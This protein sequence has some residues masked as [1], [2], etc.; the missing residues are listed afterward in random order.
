MNRYEFP[1]LDALRRNDAVTAWGMSAVAA[2]ALGL[3]TLLPNQTAKLATLS[4]ASGSALMSRRLHTSNEELDLQLGDDRYIARLSRQR[5]LLDVYGSPLSST[6]AIA[7]ATTPTLFD[8]EEL[9][10]DPD[11][12]PHGLI[13]GK[14]GTGKTTLAEWLGVRLGSETRVAFA[15]HYKPGDWVGFHSVIGLGRNYGTPDDDVLTWDDVMDGQN[16]TIAQGLLALKDEMVRRYTLYAQGIFDYPRLDVYLDEIPAVY[17]ALGKFFTGL[18]QPLVLEAR[19]VGIRLWLLSQGKQV[20]MLGFEGRSDIREN[21]T[22]IR[23]GNFAVDYAK[24]LVSKRYMP[25]E[26]LAW[27][28]SQARPILVDDSPARLPGLTEMKALIA[29]KSAPELVA[30]PEVKSQDAKV[31]D[32]LDVFVPQKASTLDIEALDQDTLNSYKIAARN[33]MERG[34]RKTIIIKKV[35]QI[36][37]T[38]YPVGTKLWTK[39]ELP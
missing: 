35:W 27:L 31:E 2:G 22:V 7:G 3:A 6:P 24:S 38:Y 11:K 19:K 34:M 13:L 8:F 20:K 32:I 30:A 1:I 39:L 37:G 36:E 9:V 23:L 4:I 21:L 17:G 33:A 25:K 26:Q 15:P 16:V 18:I 5:A 10:K 28:E 29:T 14:T 12:F